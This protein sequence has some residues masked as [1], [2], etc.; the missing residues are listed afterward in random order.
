MSFL[1]HCCVCALYGQKQLVP[2][3]ASCHKPEPELAET[4]R[5]SW[6]MLGGLQ[7]GNL[8]ASTTT[9]MDNTAESGERTGKLWTVFVSIHKW[10]TVTRVIQYLYSLGF[11]PLQHQRLRHV[12]QTNASTRAFNSNQLRAQLMITDITVQ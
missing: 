12:C 1:W 7:P 5:V 4:H 11:T 10:K 8:G 9:Q 6:V 2:T 3:E